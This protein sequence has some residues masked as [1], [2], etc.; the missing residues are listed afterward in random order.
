MSRLP[1]NGE[2]AVEHAAL[3]A[4]GETSQKPKVLQP[5]NVLRSS[6][7][8]WALGITCTACNRCPARRLRLADG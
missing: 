1:S 5:E 8:N 3:A 2:I 6:G 4:A 7:H